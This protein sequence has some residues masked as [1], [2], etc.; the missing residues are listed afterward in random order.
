L[1]KWLPPYVGEPSAEEIANADA[2]AAAFGVQSSDSFRKDAAA[3]ERQFIFDVVEDCRAH[4]AIADHALLTR[5]ARDLSEAEAVILAARQGKLPWRQQYVLMRM[6]DGIDYGRFGERV[7]VAGAE[8]M[9]AH[10]LAELPRLKRGP[11]RDT[12]LKNFTMMHVS[13]AMD[14]G[15]SP[16]PPA[17][18]VYGVL[19][20]LERAVLRARKDPMAAVAINQFDEY[21]DLSKGAIRNR[22]SE[23]AKLLIDVTNDRSRAAPAAQPSFGRFAIL[24]TAPPWWITVGVDLAADD[25]GARSLFCLADL[26]Q[27]PPV[28]CP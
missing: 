16:F 10:A 26:S 12:A 28:V 20:A 14:L 2:I 19:K 15:V 22:V 6:L 21:W 25:S 1:H 5:M 27:P 4:I 17:R 24:F 18:L 13:Y 9:V 7:T 23:D 3:L 8:R 11:R